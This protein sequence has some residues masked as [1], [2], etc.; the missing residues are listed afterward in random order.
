[1]NDPVNQS[2]HMQV[3]YSLMAI[4]IF[5]QYSYTAPVT[6]KVQHESITAGKLLQNTRKMCLPQLQTHSAMHR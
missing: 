6:A 4:V 5:C 3:G 1:M 2:A